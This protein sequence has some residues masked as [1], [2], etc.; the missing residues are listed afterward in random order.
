MRT[1]RVAMVATRYFP[2]L[3]GVESHVD[4]VARRLN[5]SFDLTI[6]TTDRTVALAPVDERHGVAVRRARS[7]PRRRDYYLS[8]RLFLWLLRA[9]YDLLHVQ[10]INTLVPPVAMLAGLLRRK[11]VIVTLHSGGATST[12]RR[13]LRRRQFQL[14]GLLL[15]RTSRVIAVSQF[16][17]RMIAPFLRRAPDEVPIIRN[18][19]AGAPAEAVAADPNLLLS[20]GRLEKYKG[21]DQVIRAL[22]VL[23]QTQPSARLL[24]LGTGPY[25]P[26]LRT[27]IVGLALGEHVEIASIPPEQRVDMARAMAGAGVVVLLSEYEAHPVAVMEALAA[28]RPVLARNT[29]GLTELIERGWVFGV[30]PGAS[31]VQIAAAIVAAQ[32]EHQVIDVDEL[33]TWDGCAEQIAAAYREVLSGAGQASGRDRRPPARARA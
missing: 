31:S 20:V 18:G 19:A 30:E 7:Y 17:A 3:G 25:E 6:F 27:L 26:Q 8:P 4:E 11:P 1:A 21:H 32:L 28:G 16:E 33:P 13:R 29:T 2:D 10:G 5:A 12:L 14:L 23:R 24:I 15:R 9:D 22:A